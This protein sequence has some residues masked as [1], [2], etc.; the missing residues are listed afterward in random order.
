MNP[1]PAEAFGPD[2]SVF[3]SGRNWQS[4]VF[5]GAT[6][7]SEKAAAGLDWLQLQ[8]LREVSVRWCYCLNGLGD[9]QAVDVVPRRHSR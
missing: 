4:G 8:A 7:S 9:E 5:T 1:V 6:L 3:I 2:S